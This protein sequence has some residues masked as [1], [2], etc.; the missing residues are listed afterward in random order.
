MQSPNSHSNKNNGYFGEDQSKSG[1]LNYF[2]DHA[3]EANVTP[4]KYAKF[5]LG[6]IGNANTPDLIK[7]SKYQE[8]KLKNIVSSPDSSFDELCDTLT[9]IQLDYVGW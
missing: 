5:T 7:L 4:N 1:Y 8:L 9:P 6:K 2:L 3:S